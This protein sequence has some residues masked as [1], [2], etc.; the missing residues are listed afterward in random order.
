MGGFPLTRSNVQM[1][2]LAP[3]F[4][5]D[6]APGD[7][8]PDDIYQINV[9]ELLTDRNGTYQWRKEFLES[10]FKTMDMYRFRDTSIA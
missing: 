3:D 10:D 2:D 1:P 4:M 7:F 8:H 6:F 9:N 5:P